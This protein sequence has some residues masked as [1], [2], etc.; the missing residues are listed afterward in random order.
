MAKKLNFV[1]NYIGPKGPMSNQFVPNLMDLTPYVSN[2]NKFTHVN[3]FFYKFFDPQQVRISTPWFREVRS[4][5]APRDRWMDLPQ[6]SF[7]YELGPSWPDGHFK[8]IFNK[9]YGGVWDTYPHSK[10][11]KD[12]LRQGTA[13][14]V[15]S[16]DDESYCDRETIDLMHDY[17][18]SRGIPRTSVIYVTNSPTARQVIESWY[19]DGNHLQMEHITKLRHANYRTPYPQAVTEYQPG[20]RQKLFLCF[21]RNF[22]KHRIWFYLAMYKRKLLD[23]FY[24]SMPM[25]H[26]ISKSTFL[27]HAQKHIDD[28]MRND[29]SLI[30]ALDI[31]VVKDIEHCGGTLPQELDKGFYSKGLDVINSNQGVMQ[32]YDNS[33][34]HV[35]TETHCYGDFVHVTEKTWKV[36]NFLQPFIV[37]ATKGH[38]AYLR[39]LGFK[40]FHEFW[41]ESYDLIEDHGLR[42]LAVVD[43]VS[44]ISNWSAQRQLEFSHAVKDI[45]DYNFAHYQTL[46]PIEPTAF[47]ERYGV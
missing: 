20:A 45:V 27:D 12:R 35:I 40:T 2:D 21:N 18:D 36:I 10:E 23:K 37:L 47:I 7:L 41:D 14:L 11:I 28:D 43:L 42:L 38:L 25:K 4:P 26:P 39:S 15:L 44:N 16:V 19:P 6:D 13:Y 30:T 33:L 29:L 5:Q 46:G 8:S 32:F 31:D 22:H 24:F 1:Y 3:A 17:F 9:E 34:I